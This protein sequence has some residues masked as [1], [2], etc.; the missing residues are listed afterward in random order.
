MCRK[1]WGFES[2]RGHHKFRKKASI[3]V[4][5]MGAFFIGGSFDPGQLQLRGDF[6]QQRVLV[7]RL[8]QERAGAGVDGAP[9]L[10]RR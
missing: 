5:L 4:I 3:G 10:F 6:G 7:D 8:A 9:P 1:V 2:L